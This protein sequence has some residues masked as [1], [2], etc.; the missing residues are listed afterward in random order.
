VVAWTVVRTVTVAV[1]ST[2]V[3]AHIVSEVVVVSRVV[4]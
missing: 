1:V 3:I 4:V 2:T